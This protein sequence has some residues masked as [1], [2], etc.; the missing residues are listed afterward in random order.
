MLLELPTSPHLCLGLLGH[1]HFCVIP[2]K[3]P[4]DC[5]KLQKNKSGSFG[6]SFFVLVIKKG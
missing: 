2:L 4:T 5:K 1:N 6:R 3:T